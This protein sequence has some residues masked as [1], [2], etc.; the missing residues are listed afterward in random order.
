L[1]QNFKQVSPRLNQHEI[2]SRKKKQTIAKAIEDKK[3]S[4]MKECSFRP[5]ISTARSPSPKGALPP[6]YKESVA[7]LRSAKIQKEEK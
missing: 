3:V 6:G 7:R 5:K 4:E 2:E 1:N